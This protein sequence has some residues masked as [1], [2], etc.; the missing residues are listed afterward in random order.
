MALRERPTVKR[1]FS[2][3][4]GGIRGNQASHLQLLIGSTP[5]L[6]HTS[7]PDAYV[8]FFNQTWLTYLGQ[9]LED[10][11]GTLGSDGTSFRAA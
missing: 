9:S 11:Q 8:D 2:I 4:D 3:P 6:I 10:L 5:R 1:F 7:R